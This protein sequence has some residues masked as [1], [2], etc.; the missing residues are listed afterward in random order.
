[1]AMA[2]PYNYKK[3]KKA[4]LSK[5]KNKIKKKNRLNSSKGGYNKSVSYLEQKI[6]TARPEELTL[7]LYEGLV[8]FLK[9][10]KLFLQSDKK[11]YEKANNSIQRAQDI[12]IELRATLDMEIEISNN[13]DSI[14]DFMYRRTIDANIEKSPEILDEVIGLAEDLR[15]TWEEAMSLV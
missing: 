15:E 12:I 9:Q 11:N 10:G 6:M 5:K 7:M 8:R 4:V 3:P 2:N 14:Y 1:M 13:L